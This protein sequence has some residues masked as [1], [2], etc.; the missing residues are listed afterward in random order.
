MKRKGCD[1]EHSSCGHAQETQYANRGI[2]GVGQGHG[3]HEQFGFKVARLTTVQ[4][5]WL[6]EPINVANAILCSLTPAASQLICKGRIY[7]EVIDISVRRAGDIDEACME[8]S[9]LPGVK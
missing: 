6:K 5:E 3:W 2:D 9:R 4:Y 1:S 8:R 7:K